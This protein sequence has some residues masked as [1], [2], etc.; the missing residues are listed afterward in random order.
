M[1]VM[2]E[3]QGENKVSLAFVLGVLSTL[4]STEERQ[5]PSARST[6]AKSGSGLTGAK[7]REFSEWAGMQS[8]GVVC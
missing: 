5:S 2:A 1:M 3:A 7:P 6:L 8:R 4:R